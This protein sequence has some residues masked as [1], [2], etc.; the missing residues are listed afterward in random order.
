MPSW[1]VPIGI[2][3]ATTAAIV[4]SQALISGSFTLI[5]EAI[6]L[7]FWPKVKIKY[8]TDLKGQ[9]YIPS[10]NWLLW[11]GCIFIVLY[12]KEAKFME[13]AY[14]LAIVL[15]MLMTTTLLNYYMIIKRY[16]KLFIIIIV[17]TYII[18]EGAFY[19]LV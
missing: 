2:G 8:P 3:I 7:N 5:N 4:A 18:I 12:F 15:T 14:G 13:A 6:R 17:S 1:F 10:I 9:L 19:I 11:A 16:N